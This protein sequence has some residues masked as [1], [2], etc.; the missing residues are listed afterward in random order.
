VDDRQSDLM[1]DV[2]CESNVQNIRP[3]VQAVVVKSR[4]G[5]GL[6]DDFIV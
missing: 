1:C 2:F 4:L 5:W 3:G 6:N